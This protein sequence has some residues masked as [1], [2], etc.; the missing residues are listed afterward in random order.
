[1]PSSC[2]AEKRG[3]STSSRTGTRA[4]LL[5]AA[6]IAFA[7]QVEQGMVLPLFLD[8]ALDQSDPKR[9]EAIVRSIGRVGR[10]QDRQIFYFTSDPLDVH[11][12]RDALA[13][14]DCDLAAAID[15][16]RIRTSVDSVGGSRALSVDPGPTVPAPDGRSPE[17]Y[18]A[19]LGVPAFRP[20]LGHAEQHFFYVLWDDLDLLHDLLSNGIERAGQWKTVSGTPLAERLGSRSAA[21]PETSLRLDLLEVFCELWKQ[22]RGR[23]VD[24]DALEE[25]GALTERFLEDVASIAREV[26]GDAKRLVAAL[27]EKRE[28]RL[29][30]L[31]RSS[32]ERLGRHLIEH[33]FLDERPVLTEGELQL[34][35]LYQ[36]GCQRTA[37]RGGEGLPQALVGM[38]A[39]IRRTR[40]AMTEPGVQTV[41]HRGGIGSRV[42]TLWWNRRS[43]V[44]QDLDVGRGS[45]RCF[46]VRTLGG[47]DRECGDGEGKKAC[48]D[49]RNDDFK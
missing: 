5:L 1:M 9:F 18:G 31:R 45:G 22:G 3:N 11:R 47:R 36:P 49:A 43:E 29:R 28:P 39:E 24:R 6:R 20:A 41:R 26:D 37:R 21:Q 17:E 38:G 30:S 25:S 34:R 13:K 4:Q 8:E 12:I 42:P 33:G 32:A 44:E 23:T 2:A 10:E 35:A 19:V 16:G 7:E 46:R 27:G 48:D 15:L 14:E 40:T